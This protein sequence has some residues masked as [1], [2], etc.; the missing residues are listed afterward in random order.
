[1]HFSRRCHFRRD[2][3]VAG[4]STCRDRRGPGSPQ[5]RQ[6][7]PGALRARTRALLRYPQEKYSSV[8]QLR[9]S[10]CV[11]TLSWWNEKK[12]K[13]KRERMNELSSAAV[14]CLCGETPACHVTHCYDNLWSSSGNGGSKGRGYDRAKSEVENSYHNRAQSRA[15]NTT[16]TCAFAANHQKTIACTFPDILKKSVFILCPIVFGLEGTRNLDLEF[17]NS[18]P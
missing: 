9:I 15:R 7:R 3:V 11:R 10:I 4:P 18:V 16:T 13:K 14:P 5:V 1:M 12:K 17:L 2:C 8:Q 6:A